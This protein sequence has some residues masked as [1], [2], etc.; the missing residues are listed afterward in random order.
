[1]AC[2][3]C[4][5]DAVDLVVGSSNKGY[6]SSESTTGHWTQNWPDALNVSNEPDLTPA[7]YSSL[8]SVTPFT[9]SIPDTPHRFSISLDRSETTPVGLDITIVDNVSLLVNG[10][11]LGAIHTWNETADAG[12]QV[13]EGDRIDAINDCYGD[14]TELIRMLRSE[15]HL[16][17][18]IMRPAEVWVIL[19][20]APTGLGLIIDPAVTGPFL[21]VMRVGPG[22]MQDWNTDHPSDVIGLN[23][24]IASVNGV[25]ESG[26]RVLST[27][28]QAER[29]EIQFF[30]YDPWSLE[31]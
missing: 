20:K 27:L 21:R 13:R 26:A 23:D 30:R 31:L 12:C 8:P 3:C 25:K 11:K 17:M 28:V 15:T 2:C 10:V 22:P 18:S 4:H 5:D 24:R 19:A 29:L 7:E 1:M 14:S 9:M 16:S 6:V